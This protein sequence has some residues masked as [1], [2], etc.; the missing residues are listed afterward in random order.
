MDSFLNPA[1][2]ANVAGPLLVAYVLLDVFLIVALA[3]ILGNLLVKIQQPRVVGEILSAVL[4][5][6]PLLGADISLWIAPTEA[7]PALS[8]L[9]T[10]A[11][12]L[13]MFLA[14]VAF[15]L[16]GMR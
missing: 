11:L 8:S 7:R 3:R 4:L 13:V 10:L 9:A 15:D 14:R 6:P 2:H 1:P 12:I 16:S 5:G